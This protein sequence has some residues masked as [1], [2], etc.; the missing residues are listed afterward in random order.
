[1]VWTLQPVRRASSPIGIAS[2]R[3]DMIFLLKL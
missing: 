3:A 2:P 1:M